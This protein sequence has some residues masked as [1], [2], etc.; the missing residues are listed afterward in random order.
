MFA[1]I[2]SCYEQRIARPIYDRL[3]FCLLGVAAPSDLI[4]DKQRTPFNIGRS[5][6]L[7]GFT[8]AEAQVPLTQGLIGKVDNPDAVLQ[9]I[10][11]WTGG[12]PF[13]TQKICRLVVET[14][15]CTDSV[16]A[17]P[18]AHESAHEL[19]RHVVQTQVIDQW[20]SQDVPP[21]LRTIRDRLR[22]SGQHRGRL[23]GLYQQILQCQAIPLDDS[24]DQIALQLSGLVVKH[25]GTLQVYNQ[26]YAAVFNLAVVLN[27]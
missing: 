15:T 16:L 20:E 18:S 10:L 23:L 21:H 2:R 12:Q 22:G 24:P 25:Q 5:I 3:T 17:A 1:L 13:L 9:A 27:K 11:D 7:T 14:T 8:F 26:I 6:D 4:T 19:V